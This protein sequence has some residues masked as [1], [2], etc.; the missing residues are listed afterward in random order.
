MSVEGRCEM[1]RTPSKAVSTPIPA[2][3]HRVVLC[4]FQCAATYRRLHA[5][6]QAVKRGISKDVDGG[7]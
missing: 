6:R 2:D 3:R 5:E 1:C 4:S 7:S